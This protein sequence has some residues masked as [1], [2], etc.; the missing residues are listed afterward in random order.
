MDCV[1]CVKGKQ[2]RLT[3]HSRTRKESR[4]S[5][6]IFTDVCGPLPVQSLSGKIY[7]ITFSDAHSS[8]KEVELMS[9]KSEAL[10][11]FINFQVKFERKFDCKVKTVYSDNG[12]EYL[13]LVEYLNKQGIEWEPSAPYT[14][15]QNGVAERLNRT[16]MEMTRAIL[17]QAGLPDKFWGEAVCTAVSIRNITATN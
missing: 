14:P 2:T 5:D 17:S 16:L 7:F 8:Y 15:Q 1:P 9:R 13:G 4:P 10:S 12:G 3:L 6:V 11:C